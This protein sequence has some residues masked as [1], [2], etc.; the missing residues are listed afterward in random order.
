M[1]PLTIAAL[2]GSLRKASLNQRALTAWAKHL[3]S[4]VQLQQLE[5][6]Q[7]P[8]YNED[9]NPVPDAVTALK[10]GIQKADGVLIVT[11]EYNYGVPGGLK[12]AI[13][14][15]SRPGYKSVFAHKPVT[16]MGASP[17][18]AATAR[19]QGQLKQVL[20]GMLSEIYPC[21]ELVIGAADKKFSE[22]GEV[23]DPTLQA[24]L[25]RNARE[26]ISW[27]ERRVGS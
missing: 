10:A 1:R 15:A 23:T 17:G 27:L 22:S 5:I 20:L 7:L 9:I 21:P 11:P 18:Q 6:A 24:A 2:C 25:E 16:I 19:A 13:D 3:P 26:F 12:N 4:H 8:L 14:W